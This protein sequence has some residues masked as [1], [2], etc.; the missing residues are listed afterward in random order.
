M[1]EVII[2][3][4]AR[5]GTKFLR[6]VLTASHCV[7]SVPYD[8]NYI[9]REGNESCPDDEL[10]VERVTPELRS[11]IRSA[12]YAQAGLSVTA[13]NHI[14]L[15]KSVPNALRVP[16]VNAIFPEA[17]F[18]HLVRDGRQVVESAYRNW[19]KGPDASYLLQKIRS[20]PLRDWSYGIWYARNA[21]MRL[22]S[23]KGGTSRATWGPRY[24]GIDMDV[25]N[26]PLIQVVARQWSRCVEQSL[27][28]L[29]PIPPARRFEIRYEELTSDEERIAQLA[30]FIGLPDV[31]RVVMK[32][33]STLEPSVDGWAGRLNEEERELAMLEMGETLRAL[34][35]E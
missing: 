28:G 31:D 3:G 34:R 8:V 26:L 16:F 4:A 21:A 1:R 17:L 20:F 32:L 25:A 19:R 11:R 13:G 2:I 35:Y 6:G 15:E 9:W 14:F 7:R 30:R 23:W 24:R 10:S 22:L 5:S 29:E 33:K 18:I 12:L 27:R